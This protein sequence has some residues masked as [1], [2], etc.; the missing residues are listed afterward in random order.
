M[1]RD[2]AML[3]HMCQATRTTFFIHCTLNEENVAPISEH[4][5]RG[6]L[7]DALQVYR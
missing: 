2:P 1:R 7:P 3:S 5:H 6:I 4:D